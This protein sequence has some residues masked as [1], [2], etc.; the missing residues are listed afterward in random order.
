MPG[1][2]L[3]PTYLA[4][5]STSLLTYFN[6]SDFAGKLIVL[7]LVLC[8]L[9]A[10]TVMIGKYLDL[11]ALGRLNR[12]FESQV[13][14]SGSILDVKI[15]KSLLAQGTYGALAYGA[16]EAYK[17]SCQ[18]GSH[19]SLKPM[20]FVESAL[21]RALARQILRYE[22][23]MVL[24]ASM[25]SGAPFLGLLGTVWG[26]MDAFGGLGQGAGATI[27]NL[28]PGVSGALLTTVAGLL[29]AIPSVFGYNFLLNQV[30]IMITELESFASWFCDRLEREL[31]G[32][33]LV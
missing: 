19:V 33:T 16:L 7:V 9:L 29:V 6:Q 11:Q 1:S 14:R 18:E 27:Q 10:W 12:A 25:V 20:D 4:E 22:A 21:Q 31:A 23:K 32:Q 17:R 28:A 8:S 13:L 24:L 30:K 2:L 15:D 5:S 3:I 26:V